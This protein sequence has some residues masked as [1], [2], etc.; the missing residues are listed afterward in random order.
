MVLEVVC[1][2]DQ[3]I[4]NFKMEWSEENVEIIGNI[5]KVEKN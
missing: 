3:S 2:L 4:Y 1:S 5:K